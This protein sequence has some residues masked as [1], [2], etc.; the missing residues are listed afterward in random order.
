MHLELVLVH[1]LLEQVRL[2]LSQVLFFGLR[3]LLFGEPL[4]HLLLVTQ[5]GGQHPH[6]AIYPTGDLLRE[7]PQ[8]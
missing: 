6:G 7:L 8:R 1:V 2:Q 3:S 4:L 5:R